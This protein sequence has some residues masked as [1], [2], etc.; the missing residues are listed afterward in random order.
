M[1]ECETLWSPIQKPQEQMLLW[2]YFS[3][4]Q[5]PFSRVLNASTLSAR[6]TTAA[7]A[8]PRASAVTARSAQT[9]T[10]A[11]SP[12]PATWPSPATTR[13]LDSGNQ[14]L[15]YDKENMQGLFWGTPILLYSYL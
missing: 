5:L 12:T 14:S 13:C 3:H 8:V 4:S 10:S 11:T 2:L 1:Q 6:P 15:Y 9:W 7:A